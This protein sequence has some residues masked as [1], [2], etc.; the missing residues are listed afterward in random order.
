MREVKLSNGNKIE[1]RGL[2]RKE[3][4]SGKKFGFGPIF[5]DFVNG[6][7][8]MAYEYACQCQNIDA[9]SLPDDDPQIDAKIFRAVLDETYGNKEEEKNSPASGNQGRTKSD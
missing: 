3:R 8:N 9:D 7:A 1:V 6:D 5:Y 4:R 2:T